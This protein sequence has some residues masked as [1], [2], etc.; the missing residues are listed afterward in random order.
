MLSEL[1]ADVDERLAGVFDIEA[2]RYKYPVDYNESMNTGEQGWCLLGPLILR[3]YK[4][5]SLPSAGLDAPG[6]LR[7]D[8]LLAHK[9]SALMSQ[10]VLAVQQ[11]NAKESC[12][13]TMALGLSVTARQQASGADF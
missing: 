13:H 12:S 1:A 9:Q 8:S 4:S 5:S 7:S 11:F 2:V 10:G 3:V 6:R